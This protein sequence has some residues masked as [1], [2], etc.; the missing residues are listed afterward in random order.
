MWSG[1]EGTRG[2]RGTETT[3]GKSGTGPDKVV[4][5]SR[6]NEIGGQTR[7]VVS[8]KAPGVRVEVSVGQGGVVDPVT[9]RRM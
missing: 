3:S 2:T 1:G 6:E 7:S 5:E 8:V 9:K 4:G